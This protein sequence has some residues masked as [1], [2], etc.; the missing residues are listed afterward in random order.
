[1]ASLVK[2]L[3]AA[4]KDVVLGSRP[5]PWECNRFVSKAYNWRRVAERTET[6]YGRVSAAPEAALGK[7]VRLL[8]ESGRVAGPFMACIFLLCHY[9]IILLTWLRPLS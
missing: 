4:V 9:F 6:V 8:W 5:D 1:M 2:G 3:E 7:R